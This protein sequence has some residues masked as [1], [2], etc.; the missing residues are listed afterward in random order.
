MTKV[1]HVVIPSWGAMSLEMQ[2]ETGCKYPIAI[3][4]GGKPLYRHI[5]DFYKQRSNETRFYFVLSNDAP[6]LVLGEADRDRVSEVRLANSKNMAS[7]ILAGLC[8]I[9]G[10]SGPLIVHTADTLFDINGEILSDCIFAEERSDLYRWTSVSV[11]DAGIV[12]VLND[13]V[14]GSETLAQMVSVGIFTFSDKR[15]LQD[16]IELAVAEEPSSQEPFFTAIERYSA[17]KAMQLAQVENWYDCGHIDTYYQSRLTYQNVRHFNSLT[18]G[19]QNGQV[20][21]RSEAATAFRHQVRWFKQVPDSLASFL[22]RIYDSSDSAEPFITM[23]L[24]SIPTLGDLFVQQRLPLGAWNGVVRT[25]ANIQSRF[26]ELATPSDVGGQLA[27]NIYL[28][29]TRRRLTEFVKQRPDTQN[30]WVKVD[31]EVWNIGRVTQ[32]LESFIE[33]NRLNRLSDL[34]P[35]HGDFCFSNLLFDFKLNIVKMIDP[36]GEFGVPGIY[37]DK[38]YDLAKLMHSYS[39]H[40]DFLVADLFNISISTCGELALDVESSEY[41]QKI[42]DV[43]NRL[44][45]SDHQ[46]RQEV[47]AIEGLLFM[48]MLPL[49]ADKPQRQLAMLARGLQIFGSSYHRGGVS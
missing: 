1:Q 38:R 2:L 45:F 42:A 37:G 36:R 9:D 7:S 12:T 33:L 28:D 18:Y 16:K 31:G 47:K 43:F 4:L 8:A 34:T 15:L 3:P 22:P 27:R 13:R 5:I 19:P 29:K 20:T 41:H 23:E 21:K 39:G 40:Y 6:A 44:L 10:A 35:I 14:D 17:D 25:I 48:S 30:L 46:Q 32:E 26:Q 24:L 11:D 49:H